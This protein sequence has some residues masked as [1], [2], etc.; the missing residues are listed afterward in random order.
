MKLNLALCGLVVAA[1]AVA[2]NANATQLNIA[3]QSWHNMYSNTTSIAYDWQNV[4]NTSGSTLQVITD[5]PRNPVGSGLGQTIYLDGWHGGARQTTC[6]L[7]SGDWNGNL[8]GTVSVTTPNVSGS[9]EVAFNVP[10]NQATT[11][12]YY[13]L[14]CGLAGSY[15]ASIVGVTVAQ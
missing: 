14:V 6:T 8:L 7:T 2:P 15:G 3:P 13:S 11:W 9:W 12:A 5:I 4:Y 10:A 1:A